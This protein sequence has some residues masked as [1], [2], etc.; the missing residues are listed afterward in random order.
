MQQVHTKQKTHTM[1]TLKFQQMHHL[2]R[3]LFNLH[4]EN[5]TAHNEWLRRI[6]WVGRARPR[7]AIT[8]EKPIWGQ[9]HEHDG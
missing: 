5:R 4:K 6:S 3:L 1:L 9:R 8:P 2:K 7:R